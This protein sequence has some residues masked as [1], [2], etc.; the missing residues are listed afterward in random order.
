MSFQVEESDVTETPSD[1]SVKEAEAHLPEVSPSSSYAVS[2]CAFLHFMSRQFSASRLDLSNNLS[3]YPGTLL[4]FG[5]LVQHQAVW[6][7]P[8][9]LLQESPPVSN[10]IQTPTCPE[11]AEAVADLE[12]APR[13]PSSLFSS[14]SRKV[15]RPSRHSVEWGLA[16][17]EPAGPQKSLKSFH[18]G[19]VS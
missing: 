11:A 17:S 9:L 4:C 7:L 10:V 18:F 12:P 14:F 6:Q 16:T 8:N 13:A 5:E 15:H 19:G 2:C 1:P 3:F